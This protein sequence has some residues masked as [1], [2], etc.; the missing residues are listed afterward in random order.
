[1]GAVRNLVCELTGESE[2]GRMEEGVDVEVE[3]WDRRE[4]ESWKSWA[5]GSVKGEMIRGEG[6][7]GETEPRTRREA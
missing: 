4:A 2:R 7:D 5:V 6:M 1:M 3:L